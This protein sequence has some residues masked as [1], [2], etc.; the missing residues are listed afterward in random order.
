MQKIPTI[1]IRDQN[2]HKVINEPNPLADWVFQGQG[3][4]TQKLDG[5]ACL[6]KDNQLYKRYDAKQG[7][8]PPKDF[9]PAQESP[10]P[11]TLHWPGWIPA[12]KDNPNDRYHCQVWDSSLPDGT[13]ELIGPKINGNPEHEPN[14]KLINHWTGT[15]VFD[16]PPTTFNE[17][18]DWLIPL[19][20]EGIVWHHPDGR[21]AK[22]KKRD[23][24]GMHR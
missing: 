12:N 24:E 3:V 4:A 7:K 14:H 1:F 17:L 22:I 18:K 19:D 9:M 2:T 5:T 21:M 10:D 16:N 6:I 20:I 15:F 23:F 8:I 11:I 13:Y